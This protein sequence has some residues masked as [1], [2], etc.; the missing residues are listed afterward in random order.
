MSLGLLGAA[1]LAGAAEMAA[2]G[3]SG[4]LRVWMAAEEVWQILS[5]QTL[6]AIEQQIAPSSAVLWQAVELALQLPGWLLFG[7][8]GFVML[9]FFRDRE[10]DEDLKH[11]EAVFLYDELIRQAEE[12]DVNDLPA[13]EDELG[14]GQYPLEPIDPAL[15]DAIIEDA[16]DDKPEPQKENNENAKTPT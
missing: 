1:F 9:I 16:P 10:G 3:L 4:G 5:P 12:E 14:H 11:E 8:P 7:L 6:M 13:R 15:A 2:Q